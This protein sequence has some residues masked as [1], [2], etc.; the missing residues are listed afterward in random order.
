MLYS[1]G[2]QLL[3]KGISGN[4]S[5]IV[6][7]KP[8][9]SKT[10]NFE[11]VQCLDA[12][13][14]NY[15]VVKIGTQIWMAEN[16]RYLPSVVKSITGT[17]VT[18]YHYVY[19]YNGTSVGTAKTNANYTTFGVLYNWKAAMAAVPAGWHLPADA[20]WTQLTDYLGGSIDAGGKLKQ[21]GTT[22]W[23]TPNTGAINETGFSALPGGQRKVVNGFDYIG[24]IGYWWTSSEYTPGTAWVR[25][26]NF[27]GSGVGSGYYEN[28]ELGF[29]VRCIKD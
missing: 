3:Y 22:Q 9:E 8:N 15:T 2:D 21:I 10:T 4:Y 12:D 6:T 18:A 14:N 28:K 13:G 26:M 27:N 24:Y 11:F 17:V 16:L 25:S 23:I 20:E 7:D 1:A 19:D 29:S 5:T